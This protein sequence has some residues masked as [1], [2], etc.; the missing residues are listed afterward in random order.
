MSSG[1]PGRFDS[2]QMNNFFS[3]SHLN[4]DKLLTKTAQ[5]FGSFV[6]LIDAPTL[7]GLSAILILFFHPSGGERRRDR[8]R[9]IDGRPLWASARRERQSQN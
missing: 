7:A 4:N 9:E 2:M 1:W 8:E 3:L 5:K 6:L